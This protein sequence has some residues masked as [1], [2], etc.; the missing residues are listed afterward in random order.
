M[1]QFTETLGEGAYGEVV[2]AKNINTNEFAAV[3]VIDINRL[4]GNDVV[5]RKEIDLHK[6]FRHENIIRFYGYKQQYSNYYL[7]LEYAAGGELFDKIEP[8]VGMPEY[9]AQHYFKQVVA[10]MA[11]LHSLGVAHRDLKPENLLVANNNILKICDFGLATLFRSQTTKEE[12]KL[13]TYC[14]TA[15]YSSPEVK[16]LFRMSTSILI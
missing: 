3:K 1:W 7:F 16:R 11:Y 9:L 12:R 5:I 15:P 4:K 2:L 14:G 10:G 6:L 13:T 8:D